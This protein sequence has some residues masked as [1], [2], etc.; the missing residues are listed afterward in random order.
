MNGYLPVGDH[1]ILFLNCKHGILAVLGIMKRL[2]RNVWAGIESTTIFVSFGPK[3]AK[4]HCNTSK[5]F[6]DHVDP[7]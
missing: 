2:S 5:D 6:H 3:R 1:E 4:D 7:A